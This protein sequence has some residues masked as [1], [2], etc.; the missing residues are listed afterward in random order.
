MR[1]LWGF[2]GAVGPQGSSKVNRDTV[3]SKI[4][5]SESCKVIK[6][7]DDEGTA[8]K[9]APMP[10]KAYAQPSSGSRAS[11]ALPVTDLSPEWDALMMQR[12]H[13]NGTLPADTS[14][15]L[16]TLKDN[17]PGSQAGV[18]PLQR[19]ILRQKWRK[20]A[21]TRSREDISMGVA[22]EDDDHYQELQKIFRG[23]TL[24]GR[25]HE[26]PVYSS[27]HPQCPSV[28]LKRCQ[29]QGAG[30]QPMPRLRYLQEPPRPRYLAGEKVQ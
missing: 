18:S 23:S 4:K 3:G 9:S 17:L 13:G 5:R 20:V 8:P 28:K 22:H 11:C 16:A 10:R 1:H 29:S 15:M 12:P 2:K 6:P 7:V 19:L 25:V 27:T 30:R 26:Q 14:R 24:V 21:T